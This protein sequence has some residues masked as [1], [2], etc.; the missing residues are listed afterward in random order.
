VVITTRLL[1][2]LGVRRVFLLGCDFR[3]A[4]R[5][6]NYA[7]PQYRNRASIASNN[8]LYATLNRRLQ[9][10]GPYFDEAGYQV[11]NCT[12]GSGLTVYPYV[13]RLSPGC[14]RRRPRSWNATW[15]T[16]FDSSRN[17][18]ACCAPVLRRHPA[19]KNPTRSKLSEPKY[20]SRFASQ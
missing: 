10:L 16:Q 17:C 20:L 7:F 6:P 5:Q 18:E 9:R 15:T 13:P 4:E 2:Y 14:P 19:Q 3:M 12:P 8:R 1:Y 11:F